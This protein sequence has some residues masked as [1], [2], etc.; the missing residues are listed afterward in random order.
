MKSYVVAPSVLAFTALFGAC[1]GSDG[2]SD[3]PPGGTASADGGTGAES[4]QGADAA[5]PYDD[6]RPDAYVA[7]WLGN[8]FS[9]KDWMQFNVDAITVLPDGTVAANTFW[10]EAGHEFA[11]YKNGTFVAS[12]GDLHG[13]GRSGGMA[14]T[15]D[16][17]YVYVAMSQ[18]GCDGGNT[19]TNVNGLPRYPACP[20]SN[21]P[22]WNG[23]RRYTFDGKPAPFSAGYAVDGAL[24]LVNMGTATS[25]FVVGLTVHGGELYVSD[26]ARISVFDTS[27]LGKTP[28]RSWTSTAGAL[29][30]DSTGAIWAIDASNTKVVRYSSTG[31]LQAQSVNLPG[32]SLQSIFVDKND[33]LLV[34]DAG[35]DQTIKT[36]GQ[37]TTNPTMTGTIG[38]VGGVLSAPRGQVAPDRLNGPTGV[39]VDAA[40]NVYVSENGRG[41]LGRAAPDGGGN[42]TD[43]RAFA[44]DGKLSWRVFANEFVDM[45]VADPTRD[46]ADVY[47]KDTHYL[48]DLTKSAGQEATDVAYTLEAFTYPD[49]PRLHLGNAHPYARSVVYAGGAKLLFLS[50]MSQLGL[51]IY[52]F[53]GEIA[54]P[55]GW[56]ADRPIK[57]SEWPPYHPTATAGFLWMDTNGNGGFEADEYAAGTIH[58]ASVWG[59]S[60][61][62][63]ASVWEGQDESIVRYPFQGL[64]SHGSPIYSYSSAEPFPIPA[65]FGILRR[66]E[67]DAVKDV[68]Y[69]GGFPPDAVD[70]GCFNSVGTLVAR[71]DGWSASKGAAPAT[72][73]QTMPFKCAASGPTTA[74]L[75][76]AGSRFFIGNGVN[77]EVSVYSQATGSLERTFVPAPHVSG[78]LDTTYPLGAFQRASGEYLV[79]MENDL[80]AEVLMYRW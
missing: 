16:D 29:A 65:D 39:T 66:V 3:T 25:G 69:L 24:L 26:G 57:N 2:A 75:S 33:R 64:D 53:D 54:V 37:I 22:I 35:P 68:M 13:Y 62:S 63:N 11:L 10:D 61:D 56:F 76:F 19:K 46:G 36:F 45:A 48:L 32:S 77:G 52:R 14:I 71:Y 58:S 1:G 27:N 72:W 74:G 34:A 17:K 59:W 70:G 78:Y 73:K 21:P 55:C 41:H 50:T 5:V 7:S 67:Y 49:D 38:V 20:A 79:F 28:K 40:G 12:P 6:N 44:P 18:G 8:S 15:S 80:R 23:V 51:F 30:S 60:V 47:T 9:G 42:N 4:G 43:I 31:A